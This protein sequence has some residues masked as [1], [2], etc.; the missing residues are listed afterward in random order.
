MLAPSGQGET[1]RYIRSS[2]RIGSGLPYFGETTIKK[3]P[4]FF[5]ASYGFA[6]D[7]GGPITRAF[8]EALGPKQGIFDSRVHM[9]MP[10]WYP[11]IPGWHHDDIPRSREDKQPNYDSPEYES[12]HTMALVNGVI[13]PTEFATGMAVLPEV[14]LGEGP[15][16]KVWHHAIERQIEEG[17]LSREAVPDRTLIHFDCYGFHQ[18]VPAIGN[19]FRWF[20]RFSTDTHR[21]IINEIRTQ[22][23]VYLSDVTEGW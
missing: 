4:C 2:Y 19:G 6:Y 1:R 20:G 12:K 8:L 14:P 9:L 16:Y 3:E 21:P 22:S 13:C 5:S 15:I 17:K 23:Q 18:G 10:G 7:N 11:C